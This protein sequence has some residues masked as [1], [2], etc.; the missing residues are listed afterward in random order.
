MLSNITYTREVNKIKL[1]AWK[2]RTVYTQRQRQLFFK[3]LGLILSSGLSLLQG[4]EL[5]KLQG[6]RKML[7]VYAGLQEALVRGRSL[8]EAMDERKEFFSEMAIA[9]TVVGEESGRLSEVLDEL[10]N[11]YQKQ[12]ELKGVLIKATLYPLFLLV[13][14]LTVL[15]FFLIFVLP[16]LG[17]AYISLQ[18][19]PDG[20]LSMLLELRTLLAVEGELVLV[21]LLVVGALLYKHRNG[22]IMM[23]LHCPLAGKVYRMFLE[24]RF[25]KLMALML[26]S[27]VD[28]VRAVGLC[29]AAIGNDTYNCWLEILSQRLQKGMDIGNAVGGSSNFFSPITIELVTIG[30]ATGHLPQMLEEAARIGENNLQDKLIKTKELLAPCLLLAAS[31]VIGAVVCSV[32]EPLFSLI[33]QIS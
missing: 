27:G 7:P 33:G 6:E 22:M 19:H 9:L 14:S 4:L 16:V 23:V 24:I 12:E 10:S 5:M 21:G 15:S 1:E 28:I 30:A 17:N 3:Q 20:V 29:Q 26:H 25:C 32:I 11:Y 2:K 31:V 18:I 13:F 8:A